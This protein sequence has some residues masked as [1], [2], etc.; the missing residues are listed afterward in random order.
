MAMKLKQDGTKSFYREFNL[1]TLNAHPIGCT[2]TLKL[3]TKHSI[4]CQKWTDC[5]QWFSCHSLLICDNWCRAVLYSKTNCPADCSANWMSHTRFVICQW[6]NIQLRLVR[7]SWV[8]FGGSGARSLCYATTVN[9]KLTLN[10]NFR[11]LLYLVETLWTCP[12]T[13]EIRQVQQST[14]F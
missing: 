13:E 7:P 12:Q 9:E 11:S 10:F 2:Q 8:V 4:L 1:V 3:E 5:V 14:K 6:R